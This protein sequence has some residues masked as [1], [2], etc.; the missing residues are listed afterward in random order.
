[1]RNAIEEYK[2][3]K[4]SAASSV[5]SLLLRCGLTFSYLI[6]LLINAASGDPDAAQVTIPYLSSWASIYRSIDRSI[7]R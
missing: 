6:K 1:M 7:D 2:A 5:Q 3:L 4:P